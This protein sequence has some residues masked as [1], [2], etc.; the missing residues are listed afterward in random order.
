[1]SRHHFI[2]DWRKVRAYL[3]DPKSDWKPKAALVLA[4]LYLL[5]PIDFF[6]DIA[7][8]LGWLDD[9]GFGA[10]AVGYLISKSSKT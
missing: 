6:P 4:L 7:P 1:M 9:L 10:L 8:F 3:R 2:P 5:W